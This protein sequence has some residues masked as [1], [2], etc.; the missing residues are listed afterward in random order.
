MEL[1]VV[2]A[3]IMLVFLA[4]FLPGMHIAFLLSLANN[5]FP[6]EALMMMYGSFSAFVI[7]Q[8]IV[9]AYLPAEAALSL[10]LVYRFTS[11]GR[12]KEFISCWLLAGLFGI[13][14]AVLIP[15]EA[16]AGIISLIKPISFFLV[17]LV[18][19]I[20]VWQNRKIEFVVALLLSGII[21][22]LGISLRIENAFLPIFTGLFSIP[23]LLNGYYGKEAAAE[24][25]EN[26]EI[27]LGAVAKGSVMGV[28]LSFL[29]FGI[30]AI[31]APSVL[32]AAAYPFLSDASL[33]SYFA[34]F[35]TSQYYMSFTGAESNAPRVSATIQI[36]DAIK[37]NSIYFVLGYAIGALAVVAIAEK[38][39]KYIRKNRISYALAIAMIGLVVI[40][41]SGILGMLVLIASALVGLRFSNE[42]I[43]LLGAIIIPYIL[44]SI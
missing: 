29:S 33:L 3:G 40:L 5:I 16:I 26:K 6:P 1:I 41:T 11:S 42:R 13:L 36:L 31:G 15:S 23:F 24:K 21:G 18:L 14:L 30:P 43:A 2:F 38:L 37:G 44:F 28:L 19:L 12:I 32:G 17:A 25:K 39:M 7:I 20:N 35:S 9:Y 8:T 34:S 22:Y 4:S 10:P 27:S